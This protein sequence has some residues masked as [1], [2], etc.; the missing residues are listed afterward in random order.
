MLFKERE[1][2]ERTDVWHYDPKFNPV[3]VAVLV[4]IFV[5]LALVVSSLWGKANQPTHISDEALGSAV[6]SQEGATS[7][8]GYSF[9]S[10][11]FTNVLV[12]TVDDVSAEKPQLK[13]AEILTLDA[14]ARTAAIASIP[15]DTKVANGETETTLAELY[16]EQGPSACIVPIAGASNLR[17]THVVVAT[18]DVWD[19]VAALKGHGVSAILGSSSDILSSIN[20]DMS[21]S[22]MMSLAELVQSIGV[23]NFQHFDAA[24][25]SEDN[26]AGGTRSVLDPVQLGVQ[27]GILVAAQ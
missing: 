6:K 13:R 20:T 12:L 18:E 9:S 19:K 24:V 21:V 26:G 10:H 5:A 3:A 25:T 27:L 14:T 2:F 17:M 15:L 22:D 11:S 8:D 16:Q 4:V 1:K 7:P 23:A